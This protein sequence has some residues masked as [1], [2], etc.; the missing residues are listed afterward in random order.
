MTD[1]SVWTDEE[2]SSRGRRRKRKRER[3]GL[4]AVVLSLLVVLALL[5]GAAFVV[6]GAGS[7]L[8][9]VFSSGAPDYP[10]PGRGEVQIQVKPGD[11]AAAVGRTLKKADVVKS[12][13]AFVAAA[14]ASPDAAT[15]QPG[16]YR[17]H[18]QMKATEA[19]TLL[20]DPTAQI[21][22]RVTLPEG[23]RLD[24]TIKKLA[25]GSKLPA[26]DFEKALKNAEALG[27]PSYARTNAE[28]FLYPAT[29]DVPPNAKAADVLKQLF[30][31]YHQA[32][33]KAGV[34][35]TNRTP[36]E[37][38][39]IASL[40]EG[41]ARHSED[42]GKVARVVYNR[43]LQGMPLQ[44]DSTVNYALKADKQLVTNADLGVSSPYNT[45]KHAGLPPGPI[46]SPGLAAMQAAVN[47]TPGNWLYFVTVDPKTGKT[48]FTSNYKEFLRFKQE[49]KSHQ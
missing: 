33:D 21:R 41:E 24:E 48:K 27:L 15:L 29:Y 16:Y 4:L 26:S 30:A 25:S 7:K 35:R 34:E 17:L 3:K 10:G 46:S 47:P 6:F 9:S 37:V 43:L 39:T 12:V 40:V 23:L 8:K 44:F 32:A 14:Q 1:L 36:Y 20:L 18:R 49:L 19:L 45:Y 38:V 28:G 42:F 22:A 13:D 11:T 2:R 31:S 5:A